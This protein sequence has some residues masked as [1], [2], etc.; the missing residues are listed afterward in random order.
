MVYNL[1][2]G[3]LISQINLEDSLNGNA[4]FSSLSK[5]ILFSG[6]DKLVVYL[7]SATTVKLLYEKKYS[8]L[9]WA[10]FS[11]SGNHIVLVFKNAFAIL[12]TINGNELIHR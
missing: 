5:S 9:H 3:Q 7:C 10:R 11:E 1:E 8:D 6:R 2:F 12:Q 4:D